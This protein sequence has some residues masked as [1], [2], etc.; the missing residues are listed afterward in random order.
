MRMGTPVIITHRLRRESVRLPDSAGVLRSSRVWSRIPV[1]NSP[2]YFVV[3]KRLYSDGVVRY[4]DEGTIF[5][6]R[7]RYEVYLVCSDIRRA[8]VAVRPG[9][10]RPLWVSGG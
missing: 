9:D 1:E 5:S 6:P 4:G 7:S 2:V 8:P 3:G 10:M